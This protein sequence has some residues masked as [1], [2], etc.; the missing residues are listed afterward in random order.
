[1]AMLRRIMGEFKRRFD[2]REE[3]PDQPDALR[4][5]FANWLSIAAARGRV[6]LILDAL[7]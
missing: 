7:N 1:M 5:A 3:I 4:A 2:I 6:V